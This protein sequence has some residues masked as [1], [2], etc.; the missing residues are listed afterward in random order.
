MKMPLKYMV[1]FV[2][3]SYYLPSI[4]IAQNQ[5]V[6]KRNYSGWGFSWKFGYSQFMVVDDFSRYL[7]WGAG[8]QME[9]NV[10]YKRL[11]ICALVT[12][13][14]T[15]A[16]EDI[17]IGKGLNSG[18]STINVN[19]KFKVFMN[20]FSL[21]YAVVQNRYLKISPFAGIAWCALYKD[22]DVRTKYKFTETTGLQFEYNFGGKYSVGGFTGGLC[23]VLYLKYNYCFPRR[24]HNEIHSGMHFITL[25][26]G[27]HYKKI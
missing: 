19:D 2:L 20:G 10:L 21:S 6:E 9:I 14:Y 4:L 13:S 17:I 5:N 16:K 26:L 27:M 15:K 25:G 23:S 22:K 7:K 8:M 1:L 3:W 12:G 24:Y 11:G 18:Y